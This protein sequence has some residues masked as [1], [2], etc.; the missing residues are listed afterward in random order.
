MKHCFTL[1]L[2]EATLATKAQQ[3][4]N[5]VV[6]IKIHRTCTIVPFPTLFH[7]ELSGLSQCQYHGS[8]IFQC[9]QLL[10]EP[11]ICKMLC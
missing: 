3:F 8:F 9:T 11:K 5:T 1:L 6:I 10:M 7:K 2:W 4:Y